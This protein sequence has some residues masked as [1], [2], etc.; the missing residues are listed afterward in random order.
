L[1]GPE[2]NT[3]NSKLETLVRI[4]EFQQWNFVG[5]ELYDIDNHLSVVN[6][7]GSDEGRQEH[8]RD[9]RFE[10]RAQIELA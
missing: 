8:K 6:E 3:R 7:D 2:P 1:R 9:D 10:E 4:P 5:G